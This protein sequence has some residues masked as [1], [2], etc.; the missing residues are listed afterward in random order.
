MR[1][2]LTHLVDDLH[3]QSGGRKAGGLEEVELALPR[4]SLQGGRQDRLGRHRVG[5]GHT[6]TLHDPDAAVLPVPVDHRPR[7]R[8]AAAQ[9]RADR[10]HV[11]FR[12]PF[13]VMLHTQPD[14]GN[15]RRERDPLPLH[16]RNDGLRAQIRSGI[17][18]P[19]ALGGSHER[20]SPGSGVEHRHHRHDIVG[21]GDRQI[22]EVGDGVQVGRPLGVGDPLGVAGGPRCVAVHHRRTFVHQLPT[23]HRIDPVDELLVGDRPVQP[24]GV[25]PHHD[26]RLEVGQRRK[27]RFDHAHQVRVDEQ[28]PILGVV[29]D[30][31]DLVGE[32]PDVDGVTHEA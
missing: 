25:G 5:L 24:G 3:L 14:G 30:V 15:A 26:H 4:Q 20:V 19:G 7:H 28:H 22:G 17:S 2:L 32:E 1:Q 11:R 23:R 8:R 21:G 31:A 6:P 10:G 18:D 29:D 12:M 16:Q 13:E 27:D 9:E